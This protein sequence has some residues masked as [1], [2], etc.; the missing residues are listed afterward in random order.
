MST[1]RT[2]QQAKKLYLN[3]HWNRLKGL[4]I[5]LSLTEISSNLSFWRA[6]FWASLASQCLDSARHWWTA[7]PCADHLECIRS[8]KKQLEFLLKGAVLDNENIRSVFL[9][10]LVEDLVSVWFFFI[11]F[12]ASS[13]ACLYT[14]RVTPVVAWRVLRLFLALW[15]RSTSLRRPG[16]GVWPVWRWSESG[17]STVDET[18]FVRR[19]S[20]LQKG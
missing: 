17:F 11:D 9:S 10:K 19:I 13:F 16:M 2:F 7:A 8:A 1:L 20:L 4:W 3:F 5:S 12:S 6:F 14:S 18:R 15:L